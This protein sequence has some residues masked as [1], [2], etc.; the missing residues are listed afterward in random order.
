MKDNYDFSN[1]VK[2]PYTIKLQNGYTVKVHY[3][4]SEQHEKEENHVRGPNL[5]QKRP[6]KQA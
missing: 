1:G 5:G 2:N 3:E 4:F 6:Q